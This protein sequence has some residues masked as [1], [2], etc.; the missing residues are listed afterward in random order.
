MYSFEQH[1]ELTWCFQNRQDAGVKKE[2]WTWTEQCGPEIWD[3]F[4][5]HLNL[6]IITVTNPTVYLL[7]SLM[8]Y[9]ATCSSNK[10]PSSKIVKWQFWTLMK[11]QHGS[12]EIR[13]WA[14]PAPLCHLISSVLWFPAS[15]LTSSTDSCSPL[16]KTH[17]LIIRVLPQ[18]TPA[19]WLGERGGDNITAGQKHRGLSPTC[20]L[21]EPTLLPQFW[22]EM[23][24]ILARCFSFHPPELNPYLAQ[25]PF[26]PSC[27]LFSDLETRA[28]RRM[29]GERRGGEVNK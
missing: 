7:E 24:I 29:K 3:H 23:K 16:P 1:W 15:S 8:F 13:S 11:S 26:P 27:L 9:K 14:Q 18:Q 2:Q 17:P 22:E 4:P 5:I 12:T 28:G 20:Y 19:P 25:S 21:R 6:M 10:W